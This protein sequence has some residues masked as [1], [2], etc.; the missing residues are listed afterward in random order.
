MESADGTAPVA[1]APSAVPTERFR[2]MPRPLGTAEVAEIAA[3]YGLAARRLARA[4]LDGVEV[5]AS[6]GYLPAQFLNPATNQRT[7]SYGGSPE[8]RLRF[9][10]EVL[11][12]V[13]EQGRADLAVGMRISLDEREPAGLPADVARDAA[14]PAAA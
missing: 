7:D 14:V 10:R 3:G 1:V 12:S 4:G 13:R 11:E 2:V 9:L 8:A 5:V 6:H